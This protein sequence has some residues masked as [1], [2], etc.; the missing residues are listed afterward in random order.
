MKIPACGLFKLKQVL[1]CNEV[2]A[3]IKTR[4]VQNYSVKGG[5]H[6]VHYKPQIFLRNF[7]RTRCHI[8]EEESECQRMEHGTCWDRDGFDSSYPCRYGCD[9]KNGY[10][11]NSQGYCILERHC[12]IIR[13]PI[14]FIEPLTIHMKMFLSRRKTPPGVRP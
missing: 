8:N 10:L 14:N 3:Q 2:E 12:G 11:R 6:I 1:D 9:C 7:F 13:K 4:G 5:Q